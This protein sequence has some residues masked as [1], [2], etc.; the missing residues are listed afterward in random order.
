[1]T[2]IASL[3]LSSLLSLL[4]PSAIRGITRNVRPIDGDDYYSRLLE[5]NWGR[6][7]VREVKYCFEATNES[8]IVREGERHI[9]T[10]FDFIAPDSA[11]LSSR[12]AIYKL[13]K[14]V[15]KFKR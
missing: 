6:I 8:H 9:K 2:G 7:F 3:L 4:L 13:N 1:M 5:G 10:I 11:L 14:E 15:F 12:G